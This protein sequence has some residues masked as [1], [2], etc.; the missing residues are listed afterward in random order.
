MQYARLKRTY[1]E[2]M[3]TP[4]WST[5]FHCFSFLLE[6]IVSVLLVLIFQVK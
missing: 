4:A 5:P 1:L 2:N 6:I 3:Y